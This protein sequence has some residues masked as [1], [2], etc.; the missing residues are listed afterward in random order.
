M[1]NFS[2]NRLFKQFA[3]EDLANVLRIRIVT[4]ETPTHDAAEQNRNVLETS[5]LKVRVFEPQIC[6]T[7][8]TSCNFLNDSVYIKIDRSEKI[9]YKWLMPK[10]LRR[11][12]ESA[13]IMPS[14]SLS[15]NYFFKLKPVYIRYRIL[16]NQN[17]LRSRFDHNFIN[18]SI[19]HALFLRFLCECSV[20][21]L[22]SL[23]EL[24]FD[25]LIRDK[26]SSHL[27][28]YLNQLWG[29]NHFNLKEI[30]NQLQFNNELEV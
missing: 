10:R 15:Q 13:L 28:A 24:E 25:A 4:F 2:N 22:V 30:L 8:S 19:N 3:L 11:Q 20:H 29:Q 5:D 12:I 6:Q 1:N 9:K 7:E 16:L 23:D 17:V 14:P 18:R 21:T 27:V 26:D